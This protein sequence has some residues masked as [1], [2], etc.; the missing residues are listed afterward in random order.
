M[1]DIIPEDDRAL[2]TPIVTEDDYNNALK[3]AEKYFNK[4]NAPN[5]YNEM[6]KS[7]EAFEDIHY[8]IDDVTPSEV[9]THLI[10]ENDTPEGDRPNP[11]YLMKN[12]LDALIKTCY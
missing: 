4:D 6:I 2:H 10:E 7:I 11:L 8:P 9:L 3:V 5:G 12:L 1:S